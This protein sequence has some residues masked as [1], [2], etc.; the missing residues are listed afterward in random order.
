MSVKHTNANKS[1]VISLTLKY[2]KFNFNDILYVKLMDMQNTF[3]DIWT[4]IEKI[5][6]M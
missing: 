1:Q 4:I 5:I 6:Q 2:Y 3:V